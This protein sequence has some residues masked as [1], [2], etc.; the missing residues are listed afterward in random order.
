M[1]SVRSAKAILWSL[2][3]L[4]FN[5]ALLYFLLQAAANRG[6]GFV[7]PFAETAIDLAGFDDDSEVWS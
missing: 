2:A 5:I 1:F 7:R 6:P 4:W 3:I